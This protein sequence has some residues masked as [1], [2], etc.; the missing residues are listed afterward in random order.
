MYGCHSRRCASL[1]CAAFLALWT[2]AAHAAS[3]A[4][5]TAV[6]EANPALN[7]ALPPI[8]SIG[9][10]SDIRAFL[11]PSV[12]EELTRAALRRA[13][14]VDPTIHDFVGVSEDSRDFDRHSTDSLSTGRQL[15]QSAS[16]ENLQHIVGCLAGP[17]TRR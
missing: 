11:E 4:D 15:S 13:W 7:T 14:V 12:P 16:C 1:A 2:M 3:G 9:S 6:T 8:E 10:G 5:T 17:L